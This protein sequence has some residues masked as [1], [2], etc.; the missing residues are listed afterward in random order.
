MVRHKL[1]I[2]VK[3]I[4]QHRCL[5]CINT[6]VSVP[7]LIKTIY[8]LIH[9]VTVQFYTVFEKHHSEQ[10]LILHVFCSAAATTL[11]QLWLCQWQLSP[12]SAV[13]VMPADV[14]QLVALRKVTNRMGDISPPPPVSLP[15]N[16]Y[17]EAHWTWTWREHVAIRIGNHW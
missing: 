11:V 16:W 4:R 12:T 5:F 9:I 6:A 3:G 15:C 14:P 8:L 10:Y 7:Y 1:I 17:S 2:C 13:L